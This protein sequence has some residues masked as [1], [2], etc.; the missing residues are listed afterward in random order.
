M[1]AEFEVNTMARAAGLDLPSEPPLL[2]FS[3]LL[4]VLIWWPRQVS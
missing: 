2:H 4:E 3:K 1:H